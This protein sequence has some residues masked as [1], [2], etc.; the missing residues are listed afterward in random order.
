MSVSH[1]SL[2]TPSSSSPP[3]DKKSQDWNLKVYLAKRR[4]NLLIDQSHVFENYIRFRLASDQYASF[5]SLLTCHESIILAPLA[6]NLATFARQFQLTVS[7]A[8]LKVEKFFNANQLKRLIFFIVLSRGPKK[9]L[10]SVT[11]I[12]NVNAC[13]SITRV[14]IEKVL[15]SLDVSYETNKLHRGE[16]EFF[17][18]TVEALQVMKGDIPV[19]MQIEA[20]NYVLNTLREVEKSIILRRNKCPQKVEEPPKRK[21]N[22]IL[23]VFNC[24]SDLNFESLLFLALLNSGCETLPARYIIFDYFIEKENTHFSELLG[25]VSEANWTDFGKFLTHF[26]SLSEMENLRNSLQ[27]LK[28]QLDLVDN[29]I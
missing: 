2:V 29:E 13:D 5:T 12:V 4:A 26:T 20:F 9:C 16:S 14:L 3:D 17:W 11:V 1:S 21:V 27:E 7:N 22:Q 24:G 28:I 19:A 8:Y 10:S 15:K 18:R 25:S 23:S 6:M